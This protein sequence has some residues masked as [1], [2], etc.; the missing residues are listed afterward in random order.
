MRHEDK[1]NGSFALSLLDGL[2]DA[3]ALIGKRAGE[4]PEDARVILDHETHVVCAAGLI[5]RKN[6]GSGQNLLVKSGI[7]AIVSPG[8]GDKISK[9]RAGGGQAACSETVQ[10]QCSHGVAFQADGIEGSA[11][12]GKQVCMVHKRRKDS[13]FQSA[14]AHFGSAEQFDPVSE[15]AGKFDVHPVEVADA[16]DRHFRIGVVHSPG[17]SDKQNE[18]VRRIVSV[19]IESRVGFSETF[20][21]CVSQRGA[22]V[23]SLACHFGK[24][25][26]AGAVQDAFKGGYSVT[27]QAFLERLH[28]RDAA[29]HA[30]FITQGGL[31]FRS[32]PEQA[33]SLFGEQSL[34]GG[35]NLFAVFKTP[36]Y[37]LF[38]QIN[39]SHE[40]NDDVD[41]GILGQSHG[42]VGQPYSF[43]QVAWTGDIPHGNAF[44]TD[45]AA[46]TGAQFFLVFGKQTDKAAAYSAESGET[47]GQNGVGH[48]GSFRSGNFPA[49]RGASGPAFLFALYDRCFYSSGAVPVKDFI[50]TAMRGSRMKRPFILSPQFRERAWLSDCWRKGVRMSGNTFG[51]L[52]RLTTFGESHGAALGGIIDGCPSGIPISEEMIQMDLDRRR[53][54]SGE[55][56]T[57]RREPDRIRLLSGIFEGRTTGTPIAFSIENTNQRSGDYGPL[58]SVWRP[59]HADMAYGAKYGV[60]DFRGGGRSSGRETVAR[61]AGGAVARAL[62]ACSGIR[63]RAYTLELGGIAAPESSSESRDEAFRRP[64]CAPCDEIVETWNDFVR[65]VRGDGDTVGGVVRIEALNVPAGLGEPVFDRLDAVLAMALMSVGAVKGVEVGDGFAAA[66]SLGSQNNDALFPGGNSR[67]PGNSAT[68]HCGGILGGI[69]SGQPIVLTVAVKPIPSIAKEQ[70]SVDMNGQPVCLRVGGRHDICAIPRIVPVLEAMTALTLADALLMQRRMIGNGEGA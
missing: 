67:H 47:Y 6:V 26:I 12:A 46:C 20:L 7:E 31:F 55:G 63:I 9:N 70:Q 39:A 17:Q 37:Q 36:G 65:A 4:I 23:S 13:G 60:R 41:L 35:N 42:V 28:D 50:R 32:Q 10:K 5:W 61:V 52:F 16:S 48:T 58:A 22:E 8:N 68:N 33:A 21:L 54:G 40:F 66:R 1:R 11:D 43:R 64:Y 53:P 14:V 51:R 45:V 34:I 30:G 38:C 15:F 25:I 2:S 29:S 69:S 3:D 19:N 59:G 62:L 56:G 24:N 18:L 49:L 44:Q 57:T 27:G